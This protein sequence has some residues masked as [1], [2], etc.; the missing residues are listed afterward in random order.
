ML[1]YQGN[2]NNTRLFVKN[3]HIECSLKAGLPAARLQQ[4][5]VSLVGSWSNWKV[6]LAAVLPACTNLDLFK[7]PLSAT[8]TEAHVGFDVC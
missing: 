7:L 1:L 4:T 2:I 8:S 5:S 3:C 6:R